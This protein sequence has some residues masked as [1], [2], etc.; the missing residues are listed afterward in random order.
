MKIMGAGNG[1]QWIAWYI[2]NLAIFLVANIII[3]FIISFK[4]DGERIY[5][6]SDL[7]VIFAFLFFYSNSVILFAFAF[8][9][10][11]N[12]GK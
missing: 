8:T 7:S 3:V 4:V 2:H 9:T 11:F 6:F 5:I 1:V 12:K 10:F